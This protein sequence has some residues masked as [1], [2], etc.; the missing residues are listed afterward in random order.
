MSKQLRGLLLGVILFT[1]LNVWAEEGSSSSSGGYSHFIN[2]G[3][4]LRTGA[5]YSEAFTSDDPTETY[6]VEF[7]FEASYS[8]GYEAR[9]A[10]KNAWGNAFGFIYSAKRE[11]DSLTIDG[12]KY[13]V[14]GDAASVTMA[15]LYATLIYRWETFY[16]PFGF[17]L[18]RVEYTPP[19]SFDGDVTS[20]GGLGFIFALGWELNDRFSLE[21]GGALLSGILSPSLMV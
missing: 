7:D 17:S 4:D 16:I 2:L 3:Y 18:N 21:Y 6:E 20:N 13:T 8:V 15:T 14:T 5:S 19:S 10:P 12:D 1:G 11:V 9:K